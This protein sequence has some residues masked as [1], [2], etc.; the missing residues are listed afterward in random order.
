MKGVDFLP[1][2]IAFFTH[3]VYNVIGIFSIFALDSALRFMGG[4]FMQ[5]ALLL[6]ALLFIAWDLFMGF[7]RGFFPALLRLGFII[8]CFLAAYLLAI[9]LS[10]VLLDMPM[11]FLGGQ[12]FH[13]AYEGYLSGQEGLSAALSLAEAI[14][15]LVLHLPDVLLSEVNFLVVFMLLRL[16]TLPLSI[17]L[18]R[19]LFGKPEKKSKA[20]KEVEIAPAPETEEAVEAEA[21]TVAENV[22]KAAKPIRA[23]R[24]RSGGM[25]IGLLQAV[26][27]FAVL[28]V[29]IFGV[30]EFGERFY[31]A[32]SDAEEVVLADISADIKTGLVDPANESFVTKT[33]DTV[34][35]RTMCVRIFHGLS[36]TTLVLS[37]GERQIDYFNYLESAFPAV[38]ALLKLA[39]VDP[40]HMTDKDYENLATVLR[41]AQEHEDLAP[42]IQTSVTRVVEE[43]VE[44]SYRASA[45]VI[46]VG[47]SNKV[48]SAKGGLTAEQLKKEVDSI[49]KTMKVIQCATSE[50]ANGAFEE[51][52]ASAL[53]DDIIHTSM[54][55]ET[56]IE[57]A[58]DVE[59]RV[60][61]SK[62]FSSS[63]EEKADMKAEIDAYRAESMQNRTPEEAA[64]ILE[65]TDALALILYLDLEP[66]S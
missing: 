10:G 1:F 37:N 21:V 48:V 53:V 16:L 24:F 19:L 36:N 3:I 38:S 7:R 17:P 12:T 15:Q 39:D 55:Y 49:K 18:S 27:C 2:S 32:F 46:V 30:V 52:S 34:G 44:E 6:L 26:V 29:P 62:D 54:L 14:E 4:V 8:V 31:T 22:E 63:D 20:K 57:A 40:E 58:N 61:L 28:L 41:T 47:F 9:P 13:A 11:P 25:V 45:N 23:G 56:I 42:A 51:V 59:Q 33:C 43:F 64:K 65:I 35:I 50:S 5:L 60:T 66:I